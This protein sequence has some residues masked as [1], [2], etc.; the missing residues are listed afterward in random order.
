MPM[1]TYLA[2]MAK[3][4][5]AARAQLIPDD[6]QLLT[7]LATYMPSGKLRAAFDKMKTPVGTATLERAT[8]RL[9][10]ELYVLPMDS[11][12][13]DQAS[14]VRSLL[15]SVASGE[16]PAKD[17]IINYPNIVE[18]YLKPLKIDVNTL[19]EP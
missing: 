5:P 12:P 4:T 2:R 9:F 16:T 19:Y 8:G 11:A 1:T 10:D 14:G 3:M 7:Y 15:A 18:Y 6:P 17:V 13:Y